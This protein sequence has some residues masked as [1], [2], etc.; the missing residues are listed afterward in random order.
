VD[1][2]EHTFNLFHASPAVSASYVVWISVI[3]VVFSASAGVTLNVDW[4]WQIC[5]TQ[6]SALIELIPGATFQAQG[7]VDLD[8]L[9]IK[10]GIELA[11]QVNTQIHP[12]A[13]VHGSQCEVGFDVLRTNSPMDAFFQSYFQMEDCFLW[14]FNCKWK[15]KDTQT[16]WQWAL[17]SSSEVLYNQAWKI[18]L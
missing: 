1:C 18:A 5:D 9:I 10:A 6:L 12:Q 8:L 13:Y 15:N 2:S 16:W 11:A 3:P 4:G 7:N 14:I 17:P